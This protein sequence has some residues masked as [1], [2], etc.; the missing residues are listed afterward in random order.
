[1]GSAEPW[2]TSSPE[3]QP[4][5]DTDTGAVFG[6]GKQ[7]G[8][9]YGVVVTVGP[10]K[11]SQRGT[12][13]NKRVIFI[14]NGTYFTHFW[15]PHLH[16]DSLCVRRQASATGCRVLEWLLGS[17]LWTTNC[18]LEVPF[19]PPRDLSGSLSQRQNSCFPLFCFLYQDV[20]W[21]PSCSSSSLYLSLRLQFVLCFLATRSFEW[22]YFY[23]AL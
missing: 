17:S 1:M 15:C 4:T 5:L 18:F 14:L 11:G 6:F 22:I 19:I 8:P 7:A 10:G 13:W 23:N 12:L 2:H 16:L 21:H 20:L 3:L 9:A